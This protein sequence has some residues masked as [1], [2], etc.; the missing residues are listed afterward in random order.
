MIELATDPKVEDFSSGRELEELESCGYGSTLEEDIRL[1][2]NALLD[3]F[4]ELDMDGR[5]DDVL[6]DT[7]KEFDEL[8]D[9]GRTGKSLLLEEDSIPESDE[10]VKDLNEHLS[11]P[12]DDSDLGRELEEL[13]SFGSTGNIKLLEE[14]SIIVVLV[15]PEDIINETTDELGF[16]EEAKLDGETIKLEELDEIEE[17]TIKKQDELTEEDDKLDSFVKLEDTLLLL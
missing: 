11:D 7:E 1:D 17:N 15:L 14:D 13:E 16:V 9:S 4:M 8:E 3:D 10:L 5:D 12:D 6:D 2:I